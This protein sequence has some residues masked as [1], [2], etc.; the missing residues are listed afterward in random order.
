M[1]ISSFLIGYQA[2]KNAGG[3]SSSDVRYV[4]FMSYDGSVEYG[5]KA[6]AVGDDCADPIARGIFATPTRESDVQYNYTFAGWATTPNGGLDS[7]AL[8]AVNE[9]RTVYANYIAAI[10]YYTITYYDSDTVLKT[11]SLACGSMPNFTPAKKDG[12]SFDGWEP[13]LATVTGDASYYAQWSK[14]VSFAGST[15][16]D[17][18]KVCDEGRAASVFSVG[19]ERVVTMNVDGTSVDVIFRIVGINHD[20]K[21]DGTKAGIS[22]V[23]KN[24]LSA[25]FMNNPYY[26]I[27]SINKPENGFRRT[28]LDCDDRKNL[29][30]YTINCLPSDLVEHIKPVVKSSQGLGSD[31]YYTAQESIDTL[32][33]PSVSEYG[34]RKAN[35]T[36]W[37]QYEEG[38][39]YAGFDTTAEIKGYLQSP[40]SID[41]SNFVSHTTRSLSIK[42][43]S[44]P[45]YVNITALDLGS[46][47][48]H[49]AR[50]GFCI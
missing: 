20:D 1:N 38:S 21:E 29:H 19:N 15:W 5:K 36:N 11:E 50:I 12:Y 31:G 6:V 17:I 25:K 47:S 4:T 37:I 8:K 48:D 10:R 40:E 43:N 24:I 13:A 28:W 16:A 23:S 7:N 34:M 42:N 41:T 46:A 49:N 45:L 30:S 3:G 26:G 18:A 2:G 14:A 27:G 32:W 9:D 35:G 33:I 39:V 22:V 44:F